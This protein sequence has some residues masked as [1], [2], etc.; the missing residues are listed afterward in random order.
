MYGSEVLLTNR[1]DR[2]S[3]FAVDKR[4]TEP[5]VIADI[6]QDGREIRWS[7]TP[8]GLHFRCVVPPRGEALVKVRYH[9]TSVD[10]KRRPSLIY[11]LSVAARRLLSEFRDEYVQ[12][13]YPRQAEPT[14]VRNSRR[15][16]ASATGAASV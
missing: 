1:N 4:E 6:D 3:E 2:V 11:G 15:A 7:H 14:V 16:A 5:S 12:R 13:L 8:G 9:G 10:R